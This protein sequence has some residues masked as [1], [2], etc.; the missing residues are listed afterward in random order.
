MPKMIVTAEKLKFGKDI[1]ARGAE[2]NAT[3]KEA[4]LLIGIHRAAMAEMPKN[5]TDI[6]DMGRSSRREPVTEAVEDEAPKLRRTYRTR[7]MIAMEQ[8]EA[9]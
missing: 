1:L 8:E 5:K 3:E 6:P 7:R 4:R 9:E 2:F